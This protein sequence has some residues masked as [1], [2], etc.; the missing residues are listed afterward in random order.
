MR[1]DKKN[2]KLKRLV[3]NKPLTSVNYDTLQY[4]LLTCL[5]GIPTLPAGPITPSPP[6]KR[7]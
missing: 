3:L 5:P 2:T 4:I 1:L 7:N 6:F